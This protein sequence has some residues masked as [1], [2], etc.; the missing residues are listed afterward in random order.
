MFDKY[1]VHIDKFVTPKS[2]FAA[3]S[4]TKSSYSSSKEKGATTKCVFQ[5]ILCPN[6]LLYAEWNHPASQNSVSA[7]NQV[8]P[9]ILTG[10]AWISVYTFT[11]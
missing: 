10:P 1:L 3:A 11:G 2:R 9:L 5:I 8:L 6:N 7:P 4:D